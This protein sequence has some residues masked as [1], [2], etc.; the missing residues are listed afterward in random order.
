MLPHNG[1][2]QQQT[3]TKPEDVS[4]NVEVA[5]VDVYLTALDSHGAFVTDLTPNEILLTEDGVPQEISQFS[6]SNESTEDP[7]NVV[8]LIDTSVSMNERYKDKSKLEMAK[9]GAMM[10]LQQ[11]QPTDR[12]M[13]MT[14][15]NKPAA[16]VPLT[17][18]R[19]GVEDGI[20]AL[21]TDYGR[22]AL[23]DAL[24]EV[25]EKA[26]SEWGRKVIFV[27]SD[28]QD[29]ASQHK[30]PKVLDLFKELPD[31]M[32]ITLGTTAFDSSSNLMEE[33]EE[34]EQGEK[35]LQSFADSSGGYAFFP[36]NMKDLN[37]VMEKLR[38]VVPSQYSL[39]YGSTNSKMD[40]TWRTIQITCKRKG[41][42][43]RYRAGYYA[44]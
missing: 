28:G 7:I 13:L 35:L 17:W 19:K 39:A 23:L 40:G 38:R 4:E 11:L 5:L 30:I 20:L 16:A 34:V 31:I 10:L 1:S 37:K 24:Y 44:K 33:K 15:S 14:F 27:C 36:K 25:G 9:D 6:L 41:V 26:E 18:D 21:K 32:V 22:T 3:Q 43:L 42:S 2:S 29:N 12:M 8:I